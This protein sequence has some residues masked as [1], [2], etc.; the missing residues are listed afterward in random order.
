MFYLFV[1]VDSSS[2]FVFHHDDLH[3]DVSGLVR[4]GMCG[5]TDLLSIVNKLNLLFTPQSAM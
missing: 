2:L 1:Y 5:Q 4:L 3:L